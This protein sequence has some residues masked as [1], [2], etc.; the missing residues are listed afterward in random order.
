[1]SEARQLAGG[2]ALVHAGQI[3]A[4]AANFVVVPLA[5]DRVGL[6]DYGR[7]L[8][9]NQAVLYA[10]LLQFGVLQALP[11]VM[12]AHLA[13]GDRAAARRTGEAS[14]GVLCSTCAVAVAGLLALDAGG[15]LAGLDRLILRALLAYIAL[16]PLTVYQSV[17]FGAGGLRAMTALVAAGS[18]TTSMAV[19]PLVYAGLGVEA[20]LVGFLIGH[21][22]IHLGSAVLV[23]RW[24]PDL[25]PRRVLSPAGP[26]AR[27]LLRVGVFLSATLTAQLLAGGSDL[28]IVG[29]FY[30]APVA[31]DYSL[32]L[33]LLT[34][35]DRPGRGGGTPGCPA[36]LARMVA[37]GDRAR[38]ERAVRNLLLSQALLSGGLGVAYLASNRSFLLMWLGGQ[39]PTP[40]SGAGG[41]RQLPL[42]LARQLG[43]AATTVLVAIRPR[44]GG[45]RG[46]LGRRPAVGRGHAS[47]WCGPSVR[48]VPHSPR[49]QWPACSPCR[50]VA[51]CSSGG[52]G[53]R[54]PSPG[55][56]SAGWCGRD[57]WGL[58][59]PA[60]LAG[61]PVPSGRVAAGLV[62]GVGGVG[63][64]VELYLLLC[65]RLVRATNLIALTPPE[66][67]R[68]DAY[69]GC[70]ERAGPADWG[71][72]PHHGVHSRPRGRR[73]THGRAVHRR[74]R[75]PA[76]LAGG[77]LGSASRGRF[78]STAGPPSGP[79]GGTT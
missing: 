32:T 40:G 23:W 64:L 34:S 60:V 24:H 75:R 28:I 68:I 38:Q 35:P 65:H 22:V 12:A 56:W 43:L 61:L 76:T 45:G 5:L 33:R 50:R 16:L 49:R 77:W 42:L 8:M 21:L 10:A 53:C 74:S 26:A 25:A 41:R 63:S 47:C 15:L 46:D 2:V 73:R 57:S 55:R 70:S 27:A 1:M 59:S 19:V 13:V 78:T 44:A 51:G 66:V 54:W 4:Q 58:A 62:G 9:C 52:A 69:P 31:A 20:F 39:T 6:P 37:D 29:G 30:G 17:L 79:A 3:A 7:W 48:P 11:R 18:L 14:A 36:M 71:D 67:A 72:E